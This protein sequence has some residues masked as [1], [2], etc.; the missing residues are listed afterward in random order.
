M[1]PPRCFDHAEAGGGF[2]KGDA[3]F[4]AELARGGSS[5]RRWAGVHTQD[6][7]GD[8]ASGGGGLAGGAD[9]GM[10]VGPIAGD[11]F[12]EVDHHVD[13]AGAFAAAI[14]VSRTLVAVLVPPWGKPM[15]VLGT[16]V[17]P[18]SSSAVSGTIDGLNAD[19]AVPHST[20]EATGGAQI[21]VRLGG[22]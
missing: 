21:V 6:D 2:Y 11:D 12:A 4:L 1:P 7:F 14:S 13:L 17:E 10:H 15:T 8:G 5:W 9:V 3:R 19:L 18:A 16:T 22:L 20:Q